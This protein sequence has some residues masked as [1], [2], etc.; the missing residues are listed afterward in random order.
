MNHDPWTTHAAAY[1]L[2]ALD[3]ADLVE[4]EV[5]LA[6]GCPECRTAIRTWEDMLAGLA[7]GEEPVA[8]PDSVKEGLLRRIA[9]E[10]AWRA[11]AGARGAEPSAVHEDEPRIIAARNRARELRMTWLRRSVG[12]A[13]A[14]IVGAFL[15]SGYVA[16]RYEVRLGQMARETAALR[17]QLRR[18]AQTLQ[19]QA[20]AYR[21]IVDLLKD[22]ATRVVV[23]LGTGPSPSA[24]GRVVWQEQAGGRLVVSNLPPAPEGKAYEAWTIAG[25]KPSPAGVFQVDAS[26]AAVHQLPAGAGPVDVFAITLEPAQGVPQPTGPIVL[27]SAK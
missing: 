25:G 10:R 2:G 5:H 6:S 1:A 4:F 7:R 3:G 24:R 11:G 23:L 26:G 17:D 21:Q 15:A 22:P 16:F 14:M 18:E 19:V 13:A 27:A 20:A 8:P 12:A 9:V